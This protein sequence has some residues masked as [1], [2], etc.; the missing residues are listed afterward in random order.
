[1]NAS[2]PHYAPWERT[3]SEDLQVQEALDAATGAQLAGLVDEL[4]EMS[5]RLEP[6]APED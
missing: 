4:L 2:N 6:D 5:E 1:M 3:E